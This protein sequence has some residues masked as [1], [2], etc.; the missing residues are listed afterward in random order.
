MNDTYNSKDKRRPP[1]ERIAALMGKTAYADLREGLGRL[2]G[3]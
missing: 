3:R 1:E 2:L